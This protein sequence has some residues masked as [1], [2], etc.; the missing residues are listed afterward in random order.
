MN[1]ANPVVIAR[2]LT[3]AVLVGGLVAVSPFTPDDL[4]PSLAAGGLVG[5]LFLIYRLRFAKAGAAPPPTDGAGGED[6]PAALG[7]LR[8]VPPIVWV[9]L[10][11]LLVIFAP[12]LSW[13]YAQWTGSVWR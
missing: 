4:V 10:V 13:M 1:R 7:W 9:Q 6:G 11:L 5:T 2:E 12:T 8:Q 3:L